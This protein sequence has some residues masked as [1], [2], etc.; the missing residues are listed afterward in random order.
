MHLINLHFTQWYTSASL[1]SN[2]Q[3]ATYRFTDIQIKLNA[4]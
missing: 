1:I 4:I 2:K 3:N